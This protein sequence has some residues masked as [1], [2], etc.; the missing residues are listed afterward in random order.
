MLM[1]QIQKMNLSAISHKKI[2]INIFTTKMILN[3]MIQKSGSLAMD[4]SRYGF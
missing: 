3:G 4:Q 1:D 2:S